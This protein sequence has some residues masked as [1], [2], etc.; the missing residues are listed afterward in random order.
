MPAPRNHSG[1]QRNTEVE[2]KRLQ[3]LPTRFSK[4][5]QQPFSESELLTLLASDCPAVDH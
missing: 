4:G 2:R 3:Q 1:P 5:S